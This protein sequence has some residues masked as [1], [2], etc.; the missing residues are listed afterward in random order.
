MVLFI[1]Y[2]KRSKFTGAITA[3]K[4]INKKSYETEFIALI[5]QL[6][7]IAI[8]SLNSNKLENSYKIL[9]ACINMI[10]TFNLEA[11]QILNILIYN[12]MSCYYKKQEDMTNASKFL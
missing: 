2:I 5:N 1:I 8:K 12:T 9:S 6:N 7:N 4:K 11:S 3:F 10:H